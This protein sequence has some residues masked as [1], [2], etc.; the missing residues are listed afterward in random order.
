MSGSPVPRS[1]ITVSPP[2]RWAADAV[3]FVVKHS[4][5]GIVPLCTNVAA[6][7]EQRDRLTQE[8]EA[9][10]REL[11]ACKLMSAQAADA[12]T[13]ATNTHSPQ[14]DHKPR[15]TEHAA[16]ASTFEL[17]TVSD[18][19]NFSR[20]IAASLVNT[21]KKGAIYTLKVL[22]QLH[23]FGNPWVPLDSCLCEACKSFEGTKVSPKALTFNLL[24]KGHTAVIRRKLSGKICYVGHLDTSAPHWIWLGLDLPYPVGYCDGKLGG[25]AYFE[26]RPDH[27]AFYNVSSV[28]AI[29]T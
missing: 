28:T 9:L 5:A 11:Q 17:A 10:G 15:G 19:E 26:C 18:A 21:K 4:R 24:D 8:N 22:E 13:V 23:Q 1:A 2:S 7:L 25:K 27:G 29:I 16:S 12:K 6:L 3:A 20:G 14:H